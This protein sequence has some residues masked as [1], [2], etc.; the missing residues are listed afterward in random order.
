MGSGEKR[1]E[2]Q[3]SIIFGLFAHKTVT[4]FM[5]LEQKARYRIE[6]AYPEDVPHPACYSSFWFLSIIQIME[7]PGKME[8]VPLQ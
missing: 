6:I 1:K 8:H 5:F 2:G 7:V 4:V 3:S